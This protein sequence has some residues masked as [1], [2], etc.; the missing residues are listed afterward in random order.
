MHA[1]DGD[2]AGIAEGDEFTDHAIVVGG[3]GVAAVDMGVYADAVAAWGVVE[4]DWAWGGPEVMSRI[5]CVDSA[6]YGPFMADFD[7]FLFILEFLAFSD[8]DLFFNE[9]DAS[10][11][12]GNAVFYL[13]TGVHFDEVEVAMFIDEEFDGAGIFVFASFSDFDGGFAHF[14]SKFWGEVGGGGFFDEFLVAALNGAI[15]FCAVDDVAVGIC[16][17]LKFDMAWFFY[18]FFEVEGAIAEAFLGFVLSGVEFF[19]EGSGIMCKAHAFATAAGDGFDKDGE[20]EFFCDSEGIFAFEEGFIAAWDD[21]ATGAFCGFAGHGFIAHEADDFGR[22]A[23]EFDIAAF[24]LFCEFGIFG[25]EAVAW[26][27][28]IDVADFSGA[29]DAICFKVAF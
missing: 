13:D 17:D 25:K 18:K 21:G 16:E 10:D 6:F 5:F 7:I 29:Q 20:A 8:K 26:V 28:G 2:G 3:D 22:R 4:V 27:D 1:V 9:I 14:F 24:A 12:F 11:F 23:D 15:A 19:A